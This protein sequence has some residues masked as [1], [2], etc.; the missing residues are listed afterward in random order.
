MT[1][2]MEVPLGNN[3]LT[4]SKKGSDCDGRGVDGEC[5][6]VELYWS[7]VGMRGTICKKRSGVK[8]RGV[9]GHFRWEGGRDGK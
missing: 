8:E 4:W 6:V 1:G 9:N 3:N 7:G 5:H 2:A